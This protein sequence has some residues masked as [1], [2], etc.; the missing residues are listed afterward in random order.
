MLNECF[1]SYGVHI[2]FS[3]PDKKLL[4]AAIDRVRISLLGNLREIRCA[5]DH[6][7]FKIS[8]VGR[9]YVLERDGEELTRGTT[10]KSFL[11]YFE[12]VVRLSVAEFAPDLVF[13]HAGAVS[14]KGKGIL[15]PADSF[16]GKSTLVSEL[17][18]LGAEYYSDDFAI[19]DHKGLVHPFPRAISMRMRGGD[20]KPYEV[21]PSSIGAVIGD[22]P[23]PIGLVFLTKYR[24]RARWQPRILSLGEGVLQTVPFTLPINRAPQ[25]SLQVLN[26]V[27]Q[28]AIIASSD[29]GDARR[30]ATFL[31]DFFETHQKFV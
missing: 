23:V 30:A 28:N 10:Q 31:L 5:Q 3:S 22:R 7:A 20:Y 13:L 24:A 18:Q 6:V 26:R 12:A 16:Q 15:L 9:Y 17:V 19:L 25:R 21:D 8:R 11:K 29:R 2:R 4:T 27:A 1:E 14:W